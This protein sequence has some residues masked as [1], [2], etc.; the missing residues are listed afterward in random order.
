MSPGLTKGEETRGRIIEKAAEAFADRGYAAT[1]LNDLVGASGLTKGAFYFHFDSKEALAL[2]VFRSRHEAW[3]GKVLATMSEH[4]RAIDR[5]MGIMRTVGG[6]IEADP[7][8]RCVGRLAEE[9]SADPDLAPI[10]K[11]Q[12]DQWVE[13][14]ADLLRRAQ[15]EGDARPDLDARA[16][17]EVAVAGF[18]GLEKISGVHE[19]D[20]GRLVETFVGLLTEAVRPREPAETGRGS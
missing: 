20:L 17:S 2:E 4:E 1:S 11:R 8:S 18:I 3:G 9:L 6:M 10:V 5:L 12:F 13:L 19:M 16:V 15:E 7:S 14:S